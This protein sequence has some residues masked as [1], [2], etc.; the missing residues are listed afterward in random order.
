MATP[1]SAAAAAEDRKLA[2]D[3]DEDVGEEGEEGGEEGADGAPSAARL[4]RLA[5]KA[6]A[7]RVARL[8]HKQFVADRQE[9]NSAL[10][11]DEA[12]APLP[13][14]REISR[15]CR[16]LRYLTSFTR[17]AAA[18]RRPKPRPARPYLPASSPRDPRPA[19]HPAAIRPQPPCRPVIALFR[20]LST[21][22]PQP[23]HN[24]P[25]T[26][27]QPLHNLSTI[28][29]QPLR[30]RPATS[31]AAQ[32]ALVAEEAAA[33]PATLAAVTADLRRALKPEELGQLASWLCERC[34]RDGEGR[35]EVERDA[36]IGYMRGA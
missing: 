23:L 20:G 16:S 14:T 19:P 34:V 5:R 29:P 15:C 18:A 35:R 2:L 26:S 8:R 22:S 3:A 27:P 11:K 21:T 31:A 12:A 36:G 4:A 25:T 17:A 1:G 6:Q 30:D 32:A 13:A 9:E 24:L 28:S 33:A 7:A 10:E